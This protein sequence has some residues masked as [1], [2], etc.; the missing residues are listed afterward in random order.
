MD[1]TTDNPA[2]VAD[3]VSHRYGEHPALDGVSFR[4]EQGALFGLL[5]PNGSGK[6]TLFRLLATLLPLQTGKVSVCG[7]DLASEAPRIRRLL[8]V[9]FQS[10]A[11]DPRLT[12]EENLHCHGQIYGIT[13]RF[14]KDRIRHLLSEF[15]LSDR[16][17]SIVGDLSGGLRR[18]V[19]LAKGLLHSPKVLLLDEPSTGL[20]P[21][22]RRQF[23]DLIQ[24][25]RDREG[26]TVVVTTHLMEEAEGCEQ[27]LLLD[28]GHVIRHGAP[29]QLQAS[30]D[31]QRLTVRTR[32]NGELRP[33]LE[34]MLSVAARPIGDRLC[35]RT[36]DA[37]VGL[38]RV[39]AEFGD[40]IISAEVAQP[41]L[42]D[43]FLETTGRELSGHDEDSNE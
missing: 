16:R 9:T 39:M 7:R 17:S 19:E 21:S 20:D 31:G 1:I 34:A 18:R 3:L 4:V 10:P 27:L 41:T 30:L 40:Q 26:T 8:G 35:F 5:G 15:A 32:S 14:L 24:E 43:V 28:R 25:Q 11:V 42:E 6:T 13:G 2:I 22:A 12:V 36:R 29:Q 37:A 33:Q 38:Q 23:W